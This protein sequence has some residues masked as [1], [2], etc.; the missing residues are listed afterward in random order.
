MI[1]YK[2]LI[3]GTL[4]IVAGIVM[5]VVGFR[6]GGSPPPAAFL[7][8]VIFFG[9]GGWALHDGLRLRRELRR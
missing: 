4:A 5:I 7:A 1:A 8:L 6:H 9:G 2:R 3:T